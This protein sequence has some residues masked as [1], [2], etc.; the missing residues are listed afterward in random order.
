MTSSNCYRRAKR[1][2][3]QESGLLPIDER[4]DPHNLV[5]DAAM[6]A[7]IAEAEVADDPG[8]APQHA[9][10]KKLRKLLAD[11]SEELEYVTPSHSP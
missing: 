9:L 10:P 1:T 7:L 6:D 3:K 4:E 2:K 8:F 5:S 11:E